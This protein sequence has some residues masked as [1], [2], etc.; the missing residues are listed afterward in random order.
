[1]RGVWLCC[2]FQKL[3]FCGRHKLM[4]SW[5][6]PQFVFSP[7]LFFYNHHIKLQLKLQVTVTP[8]GTSSWRTI[9]LKLKNMR[10]HHVALWTC[11]IFCG[12]PTVV[13]LLGISLITI[14]HL[15]KL[16]V[17]NIPLSAGWQEPW[18]KLQYFLLNFHGMTC[19]DSRHATH[20]MGYSV[21]ILVD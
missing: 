21:M 1:M 15:L 5:C 16:T 11:Y 13:V 9:A 4:M 18:N 10:I 7:I 19:T 17:Y 20:F 14:V 2:F 12:S 6:N 3:S 8:G